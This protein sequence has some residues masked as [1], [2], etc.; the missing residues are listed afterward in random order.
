MRS[1]KGYEVFRKQSIAIMPSESLLNKIQQGMR[2]NEGKCA[3]M[4]SW[5]FDSYI[6]KCKNPVYG[7]LMFDEM[8]L[9]ND[10]YWNC[11]NNQMV[12][13]A[14]TDNASD[15]LILR[16][17]ISA[18]FSGDLDNDDETCQKKKLRVQ[19]RRRKQKKAFGLSSRHPMS[20]FGGFG[21]P[22]MLPTVQNFS[23]TEAL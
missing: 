2:V 3:K 9:K 5:F 7:Q 18:L 8:K 20:I 22:K 12:G 13:L 15:K 21:Q 19:E 17:E 16:D 23:L 6:S 14:A 11:S 10:I 1:K 4:Y